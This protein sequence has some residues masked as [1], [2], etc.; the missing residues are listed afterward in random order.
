MKRCISLLLWVIIALSSSAS[1]ASWK[2]D[3]SADNPYLVETA[4]QLQELAGQVNS[5][6]DCKGTIFRLT[7]DIDLRNVC[8]E[9]IGDWT[10]IGSIEHYFEG[11]LLGDGHTIRN[12]FIQD[13]KTSYVGLFGYIGRYGTV[14]GI[15]IQD[16]LVNSSF[17]TG[18]IA[19]GNSGQILDCHNINCEVESYQFGGGIAG[20]NFN[21]INNCS[22]NAT[23]SS[24]L[25]TG[26][27][28]GYNYGNTSNSNNTGE[29]YGRNGTGGIC[30]YNGGF[31][32]HSNCYN[33]KI[34]IIQ[35]CHNLAYVSGGKKTGGITGRND[36]FIL[37]SFN[38]GELSGKIDIGG[39]AGYNGGFDGTI[40][41]INNSYNIG[42]ISCTEE[43]AGGIVGTNNEAGE[44]AN[45][46]NTGKTFALGSNG[47]IA[48]KNN[49][50]INY[51]FRWDSIS[52]NE[53]GSNY[54]YIYE[55]FTFHKEVNICTLSRNMDNTTDLSSA[56]NL[57]TQNQTDSLFLCWSNDSAK[58]YTNKGFPILNS[59]TKQLHNI[60]VHSFH[61]ETIANT[62]IAPEGTTVSVIIIPEE[63]HKLSNIVATIGDMEIPTTIND[64]VLTLTMPDGDV[65]IYLYW[66]NIPSSTSTIELYTEQNTV[67][68][69]SDSDH[70][71]LVFSV[72]GRLLKKM[73]AKANIEKTFRLNQG[74][75]LIN[76]IEVYIK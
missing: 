16:G 28:C 53:V 61:G 54:G 17:W 18:A 64:N 46:Y 71:I 72:D 24:S 63:N 43:P 58:E 60:L 4:A 73:K 59:A 66:D 19:G 34:G 15:T 48:G 2:G 56:L 70:E 67:H 44:I 20:G 9:G 29:I 30:G 40:G 8:G 39:I 32:S 1:A 65:S 22:N 68:I 76:G 3:G 51:C 21:T 45:V 69:I 75:Y 62:Y 13:A 5:G 11:T 38:K 35:N 33:V 31:S 74:M 7:S 42:D 37:N 57:W 41:R 6:N 52:N 25:G 47:N 12:L 49:G 36:G 10:P 23:I 55:S 26:G 14:S 27:I 50:Q